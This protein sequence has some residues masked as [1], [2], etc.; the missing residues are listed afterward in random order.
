MR[1]YNGRGG[2]ASKEGFNQ[3]INFYKVLLD[4]F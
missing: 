4:N 2:I 3:L 1:I